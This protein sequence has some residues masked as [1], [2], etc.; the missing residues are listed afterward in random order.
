MESLL[1]T[2]G[3]VES[4]YDFGSDDKFAF[5]VGTNNMEIFPDDSQL[6][7]SNQSWL[8]FRSQAVVDFSFSIPGRD[9][10]VIFGGSTF[11]LDVATTLRAFSILVLLIMIATCNS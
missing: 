4:K 8:D 9:Y 5:R 3:T 6:W 1:L 10:C 11:S 2:N 7:D